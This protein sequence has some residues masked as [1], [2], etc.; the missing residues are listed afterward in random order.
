MKHLFEL[1]N[2]GNHSACDISYALSSPWCQTHDHPFC[3]TR[4]QAKLH[5]LQPS[6]YLTQ[7]LATQ[8]FTQR[9]IG[10]LKASYLTHQ[11]NKYCYQAGSPRASFLCHPRMCLISPLLL[12]GLSQTPYAHIPP[13]MHHC[14]FGASMTGRQ[15]AAEKRW[16]A[17]RLCWLV[18]SGHLK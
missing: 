10:A 9:L 5:W 1:I 2:L 8:W 14:A 12:V 18:K 17:R 3:D 6:G 7:P 13:V 16:W 4:D 11:N 15:V